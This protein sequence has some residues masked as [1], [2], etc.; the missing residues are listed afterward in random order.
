[1][2][3]S[4][5]KR[6]RPAGFAVLTALGMLML[7]AV[8]IVCLTGVSRLQWRRT[9][10][11]AAEAQLRQMLLAGTTWATARIDAATLADQRVPLPSEVA[12]RGRLWVTHDQVDSGQ[13]TIRMR[14]ELDARWI[15]QHLVF[16]RPGSEADWSLA[17]VS[18]VRLDASAAATKAE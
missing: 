3:R 1:M 16:V 14:A 12:Q 10:D 6:N 2:K 4:A 18:N 7:V 5:G 11:A 9:H 8:A 15:S 17:H 13:R